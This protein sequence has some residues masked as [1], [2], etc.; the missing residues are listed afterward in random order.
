MPKN[1][2]KGSLSES[3]IIVLAQMGIVGRRELSKVL[4]RQSDGDGNTER[5]GT[6][7]TKQLSKAIQRIKEKGYIEA[8]KLDGQRKEDY[9]I[10]SDK[11]WQYVDQRELPYDEEMRR[12]SAGNMKNLK[13]LM[14]HSNA[15]YVGRS[16][17][18]P[19][20]G[21]EKPTYS[22]LAMA[23]DSMTT[24]DN[25][26]YLRPEYT[27]EVLQ[28]ILPAGVCYSTA[29]LRRAYAASNAEEL[30]KNAS[31][32][33]G[34]IF[35]L[36]RMITLF[37][38]D[39]KFSVMHRNSE[40][41]F[42]SIAYRDIYEGH[43]MLNLK[44]N[45]VAYIMAPSL[46][47]IP[48]FFHGCE[49]GI[50]K[51]HRGNRLNGTTN[52]GKTAFS[53]AHMTHYDSIYMLPVTPEHA[54]YREALDTYTPADYKRDLVKFLEDYPDVKNSGKNIIL[55]QYPDLRNLYRRYVN[56]NEVVLVGPNNELLIDALS[57]CLRHCLVGYYDI[58]TGEK[59]TF[60]RYS[61]YGEPLIG[62]TNQIDHS[63]TMK[64]DTLFK[65]DQLRL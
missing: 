35:Y 37:D 20:L 27:D 42:D 9:L 50:D 22:K 1:I 46:M 3:V 25:V 56:G 63:G 59:L 7:T 44:P 8:I 2:T 61:K 13:V 33:M 51:R 6:V 32:R 43:P 31:R 64:M 41:K 36:N 4:Y 58:E 48:S 17:R 45:K 23:M 21:N 47:Y 62:N 28:D 24:F 18:I 15:I 16:M 65:K 39:S 19:S 12:Y 40:M 38:I 49:D 57:R 29:E 34:M 14:R 55:C 11:G 54:D 10:L 53:A 60:T 52:D 30:S 5:Y 26:G